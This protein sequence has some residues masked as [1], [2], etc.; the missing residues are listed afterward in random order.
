MLE[1]AVRAGVFPAAQACVVAGGR[2]V[3]ASAHGADPSGRE[4]TLETVFD[5][6]SVTKAVATTS[7][8]AV[9]V[10][11]GAVR[12][13]D[14]VARYVPAF[15]ARGKDAVTVR[16]LLAHA[17]GL[18]AWDTLFLRAMN[19]PVAGAL[20]RGE[21]ALFERG[22][23]LV[24]DAV[25]NA[26]LAGPPGHRVYSD[27][28]FI[29][30]GAVLEAAGGARLD[31]LARDLVFAPLG[32]GATRFHDLSEPLPADHA[33]ATGTTRP[34]E[35]APGQEALYA[36]P[37]QP[38]R[39]DPGEVDDDNAWAMGGV[40]GHAGLFS[41]ARDVARAGWLLLEEMEGAARLGAGPVLAD[42]VRPD[43]ATRGSVR[44]LGF[45]IPAAEGSLA[46]ALLGKGGP[47]GAFGHMGFTGCSLWV[48][49]DRRLSIALLS[50]RVYPTRRNVEPMRAFRPRFHDTALS[51]VMPGNGARGGDVP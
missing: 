24:L 13:E 14:P 31:R 21:R 11:R 3:H 29:A 46:G 9:L 2:E 28:G 40:A 34:R 50:N 15:A 43:L 17:S 36:V 22:R 6:A 25:M 38:P 44:G 47:R 12:L 35:P 20:Y 37:P 7:A 1:E 27:L 32:L 5:V 19:D 10:A 26:P 23:E 33:V 16:E 51:T 39:L 4:V 8:A 41:T 48:D 30:L 18:A 49:L 42:F 45:D